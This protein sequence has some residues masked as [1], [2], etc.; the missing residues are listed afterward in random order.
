MSNSGTVKP[1]K[2]VRILTASGVIVAAW[3]AF[4]IWHYIATFPVEIPDLEIGRSRVGVASWYSRSDPAINRHTANG[5][6]F[7][8]TA[9]TCATWDYDFNQ[10]LIVINPRTGARVVCR[11]NDRG[12]A[13]RLNR[14]IDLTRSLFAKIA[15][16]KK[17]LVNVI[18][19][20]VR[21]E[22]G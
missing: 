5:E 9:A 4:A 1:S 15:N 10:K 14:R 22:T 7:D 13:K 12:P 11:V 19:I 20:P 6:V 17:G 21:D 3:I 8:D 16:R 18:I 2:A